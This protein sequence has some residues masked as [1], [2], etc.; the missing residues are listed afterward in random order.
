MLRG[1]NVIGSDAQLP[2]NLRALLAS[3][4][5]RQLA[6]LKAYSIATLT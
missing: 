2:F 6:C 1:C 3:G 5:E 4:I